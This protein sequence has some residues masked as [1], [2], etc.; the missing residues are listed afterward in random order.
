MPSYGDD[1]CLCQHQKLNQETP[2]LKANRL[3]SLNSELQIHVL[4]IKADTY[5]PA[6]EMHSFGI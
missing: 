4:F 2:V 1:G 6:Y 5:T 3:Q